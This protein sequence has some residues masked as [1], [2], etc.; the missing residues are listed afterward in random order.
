MAHG[1]LPLHCQHNRAPAMEAERRHQTHTHGVQRTT[2]KKPDTPTQRPKGT[3]TA[4]P[5]QPAQP[6]PRGK[7]KP[8]DREQRDGSTRNRTTPRHNTLT[9]TTAPRTRPQTPHCV[10]VPPATSARSTAPKTLTTATHLNTGRNTRATGTTPLGR[11]NKRCG[12]QGNKAAKRARGPHTRAP[13]SVS[14]G[15]SDTAME[16]HSQLSTPPEAPNPPLESLPSGLD[17]SANRDPMDLDNDQLQNSIQHVP[18][19]AAAAHQRPTLSLYRAL[20]ETDQRITG[21]GQDRD[22]GAYIQELRE[23]MQN[24][25]QQSP[26]GVVVQGRETKT[27]A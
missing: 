26:E 27:G 18:H 22:Q 24:A 25:Q 21:T 7:E 6:G 14:S 4:A 17:V 20:N 23:D 5:R 13:L 1:P 19:V 15:T 16:T 9:T 3:P 8:E 12:G 2:G 10:S 11:N